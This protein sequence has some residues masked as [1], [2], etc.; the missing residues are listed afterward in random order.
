FLQHTYGSIFVVDS[1][2]R[3]GQTLSQ[4]A[5]EVTRSL[6]RVIDDGAND[7]QDHPLFVFVNKQDKSHAMIAEEVIELLRL[8]K[9]FAAS[10]CGGGRRW[11]VQEASAV[12]EEGITVGFA[13]L[14]TQKQELRAN[15][16]L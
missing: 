10:G 1:F 7:V 12:Q 11:F 4:Y 9:I 2:P 14:V 6:R 15:S 3:E 8:E 16:G 13:W 5:A